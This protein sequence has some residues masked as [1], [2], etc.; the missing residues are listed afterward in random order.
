[1]VSIGLPL[2]AGERDTDLC[3]DIAI[4][5]R[6]FILSLRTKSRARSRIYKFHQKNHK[7]IIEHFI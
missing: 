7:H 5:F 4:Y 3:L 1:M 6:N 2:P